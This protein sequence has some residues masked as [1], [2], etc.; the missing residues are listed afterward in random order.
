[1][2]RRRA[3]ISDAAIAFSWS[4]GHNVRYVLSAAALARAL[5]FQFLL[6]FCLRNRV[7]SADEGTRS[8][9]VPAW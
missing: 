6:D 4:F 5:C 1:M 2:A 3:K 7:S 8:P 9:R